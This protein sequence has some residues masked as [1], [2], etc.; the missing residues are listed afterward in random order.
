MS[1]HLHFN[2]IRS[3]FLGTLSLGSSGLDVPHAVHIPL[4]G[5][6][7]ELRCV[8]Q[9]P[10]LSPPKASLHLKD[11]DNTKYPGSTQTPESPS[12]ELLPSCISQSGKEL[13]CANSG[14]ETSI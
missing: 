2:K 11:P 3:C 9:D 1:W 5:E 7:S 8:G 14:T 12:Q 13:A 6:D 10:H 4:R